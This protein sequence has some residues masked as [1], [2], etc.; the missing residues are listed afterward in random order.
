LA[1]TAAARPAHAQRGMENAGLSAAAAQ[2]AERLRGMHLVEAFT[3]KLAS[4]Q[5]IRRRMELEAGRSYALSGSCDGQCRDLD[6][7]LLGP[8]G[9]EVAADL[10]LDAEPLILVVPRVPGTYELRAYMA[11]CRVAAGCAFTVRLMAR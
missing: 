7:R 6:L 5:S 9:G 10:E 11:D 2:K 4:S 8:D 1:A 3:G